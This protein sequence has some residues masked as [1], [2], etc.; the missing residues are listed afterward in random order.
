MDLEKYYN[1]WIKSD[2]NII[3]YQL[4]VESKKNDA[5]E[6]IYKRETHSQT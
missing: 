3:W 6:F 2:K 5:N 4:Y 1:K